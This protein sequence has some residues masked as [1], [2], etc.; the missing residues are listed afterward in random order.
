MSTI[1][2]KNRLHSLIDTVNDSATL[3]AILTL[4]NKS[5]ESEKDWWKE[6]DAE[7]K[8]TIEEGLKD[9]K[10]GRVYSHEEVMTRQRQNFYRPISQSIS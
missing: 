7:Q 6:L 2:L 8:A 3:Q 1:E 5:E 9:I 4:L 10:E